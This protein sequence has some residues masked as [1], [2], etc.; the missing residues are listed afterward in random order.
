M[1]CLNYEIK[2]KQFIFLSTTLCFIKNEKPPKNPLR[3]I[4]QRILGESF[5]IGMQVLNLLF[6]N[7]ING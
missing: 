5:L 4:S 7:T 6:R 1:N 3:F 2:F